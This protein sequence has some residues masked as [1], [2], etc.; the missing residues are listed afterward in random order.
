MGINMPKMNGIDATAE[1]KTRFPETVVIGLSVNAEG[2]NA[3]AMRQAGA[4]V[5]LTKE[6]TVDELYS[7]IQAA[8]KRGVRGVCD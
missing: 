6:A 7:T 2:D 8:V 3:E 5:L 1:I 4:A